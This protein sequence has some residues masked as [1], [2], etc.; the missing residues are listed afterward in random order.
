MISTRK[1]EFLYRTPE[2]FSTKAYD[3]EKEMREPAMCEQY[4]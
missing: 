3:D 4:K 2:L 1:R